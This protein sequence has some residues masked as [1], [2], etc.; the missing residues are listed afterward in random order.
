MRPFEFAKLI[1][2]L[3]TVCAALLL[4]SPGVRVAPAAADEL[5]STAEPGPRCSAG[6][7]RGVRVASAAADELV[8]TEEPGPQCS[9][10]QPLGAD[11]QA[12]ELIARLR[13]EQMARIGT[14]SAGLVVLNGRGYNYGPPP[15]IDLARIRAEGAQLPNH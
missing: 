9:A 5:V 14:G 13:Q 6:Q 4:A 11:A 7:P 8:S 10:G 15:G 12:Q 1:L 2:G 3:L